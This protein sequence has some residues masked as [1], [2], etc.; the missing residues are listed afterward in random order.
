MPAKI[1]LIGLD[2]AEASLLRKWGSD[3]S[4]PFIGSLLEVAAWGELHCPP[5]QYAGSIW[6]SI[7]TSVSPARHG[8][9]FNTQMTLGSYDYAPFLPQD[10][11]HPPFY[12]FL[13]AAGYKIAV[14]DVPKAPL[15]NNPGCVQILD[16]GA[17]DPEFAQMRTEPVALAREVEAVAG[18]DPVGICDHTSRE[19]G[20]FA[21]L[22]DRLVQRIETKGRLISAQLDKANWDLVFA[23]FSDSHC[24]GHQLWHQHDAQHPRHDPVLDKDIGDPLRTVYQALD[25]EI[26]ALAAHA[27]PETVF[28]L[29][30]SH[31]MGA[32]YDGTFLLDE[33]VRRLQD[34]KRAKKTRDPLRWLWRSLPMGL[35]R[36]LRPG[37]VQA[38]RA[39]AGARMGE[40]DFFAVRTNDNCGGIRINLAGREPRGRVEP[41]TPYDALCSQIE[42]ELKAIVNLETGEPVVREVL[43]SRDLFEGPYLDDLPDL[44]VVW[45]DSAPVRTVASDK[46]GRIER[47]YTGNRTGDHRDK[48]LVLAKGPGI[49]GGRIDAQL[50]SMDI[51]PTVA[52]CLGATLAG[53]DGRPIE[54]V[55]KKRNC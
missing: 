47:S 18:L 2:A 36:R 38:Q 51:G 20:D 16:W 45:N 42:T 39:L 3:G 7:F 6:P 8:R 12:E 46:I 11:K 40:S 19:T 14:I 23:V 48:G 35:R 10:L 31:G 33:I 5:G 54:A 29:F 28:I 25:R 32:H 30:S 34:P 13:A 44:N 15:V 22:R 4:L 27:G 49:P 37:A 53:S 50:S 21:G 55:F 52:A 24:A 41:G 1:F 17:H 43:H 26:A 9:Y